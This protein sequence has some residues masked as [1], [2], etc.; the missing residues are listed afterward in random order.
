[1]SPTVSESGGSTRHCRRGLQ[2]TPN[3]AH[4][5]CP[6]IASPYWVRYQSHL[7]GPSS[8]CLESIPRRNPGC[9]NSGPWNPI[10]YCHRSISMLRRH[11]SVGIPNPHVAL[12]KCSQ[13]FLKSGPRG[14]LHPNQKGAAPPSEQRVNR[15]NESLKHHR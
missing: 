8:F 14:A 2:H 3:S 13:V 4:H 15:T 12:C 5:P 6:L 7:V 9:G 1:M 11:P 10:R